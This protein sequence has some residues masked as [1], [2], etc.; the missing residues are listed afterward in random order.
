MR[1]LIEIEGPGEGTAVVRRI[2]N[3]TGRPAFAV[4]QGA[5]LDGGPAP[6]GPGRQSLGRG[7][8]TAT[9]AG[10]P[11]ADASDRDAGAAPEVPDGGAVPTPEEES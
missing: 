6:T 5:D 2:E 7:A 1:I 11:D 3:E 9:T 4:H 10:A 8:P